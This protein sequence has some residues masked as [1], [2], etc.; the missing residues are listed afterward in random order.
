MVTDWSHLAQG[1]P[2]SSCL[3]FQLSIERPL[4]HRLSLFTLYLAVSASHSFCFSLQLAASF[5]SWP[6][7]RSWERGRERYYF[8]LGLGNP[9]V[10]QSG[11]LYHIITIL[12]RECPLFTH[13][14]FFFW[15]PRHPARLYFPGSFAVPWS[16]ITEFWPIRHGSVTGLSHPIPL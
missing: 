9:W 13:I 3:Q 14:F 10:L 7:R 5:L 2:R 1:L 6:E 15:P 16:H 11:K 12:Q 8:P 4:I